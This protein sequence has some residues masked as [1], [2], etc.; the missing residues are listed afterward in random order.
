MVN[1]VIS[2]QSG[3]IEA[4]Q[5]LL[6]ESSVLVLGQLVTPEDLFADPV[7]GHAFGLIDIVHMNEDGACQG[8]G[9][10]CTTRFEGDAAIS[11]AFD[12]AALSISS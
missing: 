6:T 12:Y 5:I 8:V 1:V 2:W 11:K 7:I 3:P 4:P 9:I 10:R